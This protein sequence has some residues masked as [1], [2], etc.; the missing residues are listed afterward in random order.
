M[1]I[2]NEPKNRTDKAEKMRKYETLLTTEQ[3]A[4]YLNVSRGTL[5]VWRCTKAHNLPY[6]K[7]GG[8]IRYRLYDLVNFIDQY[9][10][11]TP[12]EVEKASRER[13]KKKDRK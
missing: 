12:Q 9:Y 3:V 13:G 2:L 4:E 7:M 1:A 8:L 5:E 6:I 11:E 10:E